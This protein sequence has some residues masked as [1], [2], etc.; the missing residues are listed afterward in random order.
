MDV[1][2]RSSSRL[3]VILHRSQLLPNHTSMEL[4]LEAELAERSSPEAGEYDALGAEALRL[5][6]SSSV[7]IDAMSQASSSFLDLVNTSAG[8]DMLEEPTVQPLVFNKDSFVDSSFMD[9]PEYTELDNVNNCYSDKGNLVLSATSNNEM[10][11]KID[12]TESID[13]AINVSSMNVSTDFNEFDDGNNEETLYG[14]EKHSGMN[15]WMVNG[16]DKTEDGVL[17]MTVSTDSA[18]YSEPVSRSATSSPAENRRYLPPT[19]STRRYGFSSS[20][21]S[22]QDQSILLD[23]PTSLDVSSMHDDL[24]KAPTKE[25]Q[26]RRKHKTHTNNLNVALAQSEGFPSDDLLFNQSA[27]PFSHTALDSSLNFIL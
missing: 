6:L 3:L 10:K 25:C 11:N 1:A 8:S 16:S 2:R 7:V 13:S 12:M 19:S 20:K 23:R 21:S 9:E 15:V 4:D 26:K 5:A 14:Y 18:V 24:L 27:S 22:S 17:N